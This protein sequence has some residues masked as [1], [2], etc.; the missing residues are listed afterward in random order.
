MT[1]VYAF[2]AM[3]WAAAL[4]AAEMD[5]VF[6]S[7]EP[8]DIATLSNLDPIPE[9]IGVAGFQLAISDNRTTGKFLDQ[10]F[11]D[12][13]IVI[14]LGDDPTPYFDEVLSLSPY[15]VTDL[16]MPL[17]LQLSDRPAAQGALIFNASAQDAALR[18]D[19][20]KSNLFHTI[21][22]Y[23]MRSDAL[24]QVLLTK[25]WDK[26]AMIFGSYDA[27]IQFAD[28]LRRSFSKFGLKLRSEKQWDATADIRR[29]AASEIPIFTQDL[30]DHDVLII[31]DEVDDFGRYVPFNTWLARPVAGSQGLRPIGW[32]R[33]AEQWG[34]AQ[35][36]SRFAKDFDRHM[37]SRDYAA[38]AAVR[39]LGEA[40]TRTGLS[41]PKVIRDYILSDDFELAAFKGRALSYRSWNGQLRQPIPVVG[42]T[43]VV[44]NAPLDGFL[45][46][47]NEL[48]TLGLD[49]GESSCTA[50]ER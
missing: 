24:A 18:T 44:A 26:V 19:Q 13:H 8:E 16:P 47:R 39:S 25:K 27:D 17:L 4:S 28:A 10:T 2:I 34:A 33:T 40:M 49:Q 31:A 45:H 15:V 41:D 5:I 12:H 7:A 42:P 21:P 14:P 3:V 38:W 35:L 20:C 43:A 50:F 23:S 22:S 1:F 9:N 48:D 11:R 37:Y 36:Q 6:L 30:K 32:D 29:T 46:Q